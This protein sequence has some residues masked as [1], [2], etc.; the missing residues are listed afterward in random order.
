MKT[1]IELIAEERQ[2]QI[3]GHG[4]DNEHDEMETAFQLSSAAAMCICSAIN[5]DAKEHTHYDDMGNVARFQL[6]QNETKK[7]GEQWP[8]DFDWRDGD[9]KIKLLTKAGALIAAEI[10]RLQT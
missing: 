7:W 5:I 9:D 4:Y 8:W 3:N 10:D 6:R 2:K 1:G